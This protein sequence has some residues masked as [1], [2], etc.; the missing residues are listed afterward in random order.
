[1][2]IQEAI[3][4]AKQTVAELFEPEG[5]TNIG[6]EELEFD[7]DSDTWDVTIGFSR[8]WDR[9]TLGAIAEMTALTTATPR[10][11]L[12]RTYKIVSLAKGDG[13]LIAIR[14]RNV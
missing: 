9:P 12:R 1:M 5:A 3:Q 13:K 8:P 4:T 7:E 14:N 11:A 6:L 10:P 2:E